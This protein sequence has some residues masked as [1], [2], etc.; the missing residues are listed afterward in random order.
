MENETRAK[1]NI[2]LYNKY[3]IFSYDFLFYY[4]VEVMFYTIVKGFSMSEFMYLCSFYT[5]SA[6]FWQLFGSLIVEKLGLKKSIILGNF[7][8]SLNCAMFIIAK[9]FPTFLLANFFLALGFSL[10]SL[11]EGSLLYSSLKKVGK[12][13]EFS[14]IEG[15]SNAK[16]YYFD[17]ISAFLSGF[18]FVLN[19]Y[20]PF[21]LCLVC[22]VI[23]LVMSCKFEDFKKEEDYE[24]TLS[25]KKTLL[26]IKEIISNNRSKAMLLFAF[27][28]WG[29]ISVY[30]TLYKAIILDMGIKQQYSTIVVCLVTI[31]VGF[32][33][34]CFYGIEKVTKNKTLTVFSYALLIS[35]ITI[36]MVGTFADLNLTS[37]SILFIA[38]AIIGIIQGAY[39]VAIKKYV[40]N[41]TT[42]QVRIKI[43][44]AYYI[45]ENLGK[46]LILFI[47]GFLLE[48]TSN[49]VACLIFS[50]I[51]V[52]V[53]V[54]I[55]NYMK[56]KIGLKP[57]QY[58]PEEINNVKIK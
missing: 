50:G 2:S 24:E 28:F 4:A 30:N 43:T 5:L 42:S 27:V 12:R 9:A 53:I 10:K 26:S 41:F 14:K 17:A 21:I 49:S 51:A 29:I 57:E 39:R 35:T 52:I 22:C 34:R 18:L 8:V 44:S 37:L 33:S 45:V 55:L 13:A 48:F 46:S 1:R 38:L 6:F 32:G 47:T 54:S 58:L 7:F 40:L 31:F 56:G 3:K 23:S 36:G 19:G 25:I 16:Y 20:I 11:A 15:K